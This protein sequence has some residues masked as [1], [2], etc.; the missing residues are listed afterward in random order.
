MINEHGGLPEKGIFNISSFV[1]PGHGKI[2]GGPLWRA[3]SIAGL[4]LAVT[5][6]SASN[7]SEIAEISN[8]TKFSQAAYGVAASPRVTTA[9]KV[10]KGG[11]RSMV[12]KPYKIRGKWYYPKE[13]PDY[14][15]TGMASWYGPNFHGR[16]TANGEIYDQYH[17]SAAHPTMPL[18]SYARVTN[19]KNGNS[20]IVRVNDRGPF[21]RGRII[22]V[23][24]YAAQILDLKHDGVAPVRVQYVGPASLDGDDMPFLMASVQRGDD[25]Q[26][27]NPEGQIASGVMLALA[28]RPDPVPGVAIQNAN[29]AATIVVASNEVPA[30]VPLAYD[31][32]E[33]PNVGPFVGS[34]PSLV[35][36]ELVSPAPRPQYELVSAYA[37]AFLNARLTSAN[38]AFAVLL[39]QETNALTEEAIIASWKRR[40]R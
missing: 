8:E 6:C 33:L 26:E 1:F 11:G 27:I 28:E 3:L 17:L 34:R 39:T 31:A 38:E 35:A 24:K 10:A 14:D 19:K 37:P 4:C 13:D 20:V 2:S 36:P 23:S 12:G 18:P 29:E 16:K 15:N 5:A 40:L 22:D 25:G 32:V 30:S 21:S 7:G 9:K